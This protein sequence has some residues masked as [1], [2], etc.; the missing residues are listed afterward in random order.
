MSLI[1]GWAGEKKR[2]TRRLYK[3]AVSNAPSV[4]LAGFYCFLQK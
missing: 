2:G 1:I 4:N 3:K